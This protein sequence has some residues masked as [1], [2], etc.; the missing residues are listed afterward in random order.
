MKRI[1][2]LLIVMSVITMPELI[3]AGHKSKLY[4]QQEE[5]RKVALVQAQSVVKKVEKDFGDANYMNRA[6]LARK[7]VRVTGDRNKLVTFNQK[8]K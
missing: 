4:H 7:L 5:N 1:S 6:M 8:I 3:L 2:K